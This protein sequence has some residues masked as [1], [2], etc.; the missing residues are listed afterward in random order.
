MVFLKPTGIGMSLVCPIRW[1]INFGKVPKF[2]M[3]IEV[4]PVIGFSYSP[5]GMWLIVKPVN[6]KLSIDFIPQFS[7]DLRAR[8]PNKK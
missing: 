5:Y 6:D 1:E 2:N 8:L 3:F 7:I 4:A